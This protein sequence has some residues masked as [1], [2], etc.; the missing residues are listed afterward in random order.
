VKVTAPVRV[1]LVVGVNVTETV[2]LPPAAIED[3][4]LL[5]WAKSPEAAIE[6]IETGLPP[7]FVTA[8]VFTGE[9]VVIA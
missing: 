7:V 5:V 2:Q 8:I 3:A 1:P 4:Q 9:V 6:V